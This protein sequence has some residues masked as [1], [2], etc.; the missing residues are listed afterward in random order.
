MPDE[1]IDTLVEAMTLPTYGQLARKLME[2]SQKIGEW[3]GIPIPINECSL[4]L[5]PRY[6]YQ[7]DICKATGDEPLIE[8]INEWWSDRL[9]ARV[10]V[11]R[12]NGKLCAFVSAWNGSSMTMDTL[13]AS[14]VW[15]LDAEI[16]AID[17]LQSLI[18]PHHF[19]SYITTGMFI[20]RSARSGLFYLFRR[21]KPTMAVRC[22]DSGCRTLCTLCLHPI[23][24]YQSTWA[25]AMVPTD[26]VIAH[27]LMMRGSEEKFWANANQHPPHMPQSGL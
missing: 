25:G 22:T 1:V 14:K 11:G 8:I 27:L 13:M 21:L 16:K 2:H 15:P 12:L 18:K 4:V 5:E 17:K 20:E 10:I 3:A 9:R 26:D 24:F 7:F 6:P 23:G 19:E